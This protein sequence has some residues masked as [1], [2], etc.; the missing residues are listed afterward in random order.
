MDDWHGKVA[1]VTGGGSGIG[2][3]LCRALAAEGMTVV[4]ADVDAAAGDA[5][6]ALVERAGGRAVAVPT[7]VRRRAD[8]ERLAERTRAVAG[9]PFVVCANAG[10]FVGGALLDMT[11]SDWRWL[12]DVNL[13][14]VVYTAQVFAPALIAQRAGHLLVTASVGGFLSGGLTPVY[15]TTKFAVVAVGEALRMELGTHGVGVTLLCPGST[16]TNLPAAN[17]LRPPDW[18]PGA[19]DSELLRPLLAMNPKTPDAIAQIALKGLRAN[20]PYV[21][22]HPEYREYIGDRFA[23]VLK[24]FDGVE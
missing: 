10:V 12:V 22:T 18:G 20:A 19:G 16:E 13:M 3:G 1:V 5:T 8:V 23:Q 21:F 7:D 17:R 11:E 6:A 4:V 2:R 9:P 15:S 24:A 14:G